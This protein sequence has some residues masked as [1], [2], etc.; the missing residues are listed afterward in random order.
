MS[1]NL[2]YSI[3]VIG[4]S[5]LCVAAPEVHRGGVIFIAKG[6]IRMENIIEYLLQP[7][8][9]IALIIG[10]AEL[11]KQLGV[12]ARWIPLFDLVMGIVSGC[13]VYAV[14]MGYAW[15]NAI[16]LG[17]AMGLAACGLF[18]AIKNVAF[19]NGGANN[20]I[21]DNDNGKADEPEQH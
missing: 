8:G 10:L 2:W 3:S 20:N 1:V 19:G 11:L 12:P 18:S 9:Q 21:E 15:V 4:I 6:V 5:F 7:A 13:L 16:M 14:G 17:I